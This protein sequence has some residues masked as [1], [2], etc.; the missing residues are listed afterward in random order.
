MKKSVTLLTILLI[1]LSAM[2]PNLIKYAGASNPLVVPSVSQ[3]RADASLDSATTTFNYTVTLDT[4]MGTIVIGLFDDMPITTNNF[5]NLTSLGLYDGTLFHRVVQDFVIQGGDIEDE[6]GIIIP[7]IPDELPT[8]HSNVRGSVAMAKT[9]QP[10]S[11]TSQFYINVADNTY[12]DTYGGGY[13]VFGQVTQ[14]MN[15]VDNISNVTV[16]TDGTDRPIQNVTILKATLSKAVPEYSLPAY[17]ILF[18]GTTLLL[19]IVQTRRRNRRA[20]L[21]DVR[22]PKSN[23]MFC[24]RCLARR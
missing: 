3:V 12:L 20:H 19:A 16:T 6:K 10:N 22:T 14:G 21:R 5:K 2:S 17:A 4:S 1:S 9:N 18:I 11:A 24:L 8:K 13:S 23:P 7:A 15:V